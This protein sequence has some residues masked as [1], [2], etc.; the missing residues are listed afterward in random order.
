MIDLIFMSITTIWKPGFD[1][2]IKSR[3]NKHVVDQEAVN[4]VQHLHAN[5]FKELK[6]MT[7]KHSSVSEQQTSEIA[8][9]K[10]TCH[11][12]TIRVFVRDDVHSL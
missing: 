1:C 6:M 12:L 3:T 7:W 5:H 9:E 2:K 11:W 10:K 8:L 4:S